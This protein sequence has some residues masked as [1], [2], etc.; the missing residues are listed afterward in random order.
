MD[1]KSKNWLKIFIGFA[2]KNYKWQFLLLSFFF[3]SVQLKYGKEEV[4]ERKQKKNKS[5]KFKKI[6]TSVKLGK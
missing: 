4:I 5:I 1:I 3:S 2:F 6:V